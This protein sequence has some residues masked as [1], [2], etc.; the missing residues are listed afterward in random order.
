M[1][2]NS[3]VRA[4]KRVCLLSALFHFHANTFLSWLYLFCLAAVYFRDTR[5]G[6]YLGRASTAFYSNE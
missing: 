4:G 6:V 5:A 2:S 1:K 3:C